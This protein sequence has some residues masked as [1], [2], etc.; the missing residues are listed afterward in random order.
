[1]ITDIKINGI[2][3]IRNLKIDIVYTEVFFNKYVK[4]YSPGRTFTYKVDA[5]RYA[6]QPYSCKMAYIPSSVLKR[7]IRFLLEDPGCGSKS[8]CG[9]HK[10]G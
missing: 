4:G 2:D 3:S 5:F 1:M 6:L 10:N 8:V 9:T 7:L